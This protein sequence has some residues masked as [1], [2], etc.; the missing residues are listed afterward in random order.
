MATIE[1]VKAGIASYADR[2]IISK[3]PYGTLR[4]V[5]AGTALALAIQKSV[6][7]FLEGDISKALCI[8]DGESVDVEALAEALKAQIPDDGVVVPVPAIGM[9]IKFRREDIDS[10]LR[11]IEVAQ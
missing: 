7:P 6:Q 1:Q 2:E 11:D 9:E 4:R 10:I 5:I 8:Y 3:L